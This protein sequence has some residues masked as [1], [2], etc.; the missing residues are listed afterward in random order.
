[1][2]SDGGMGAEEYSI[3]VNTEYDRPEEIV[4]VLVQDRFYC[5]R[6]E[7]INELKKLQSNLGA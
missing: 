3:D 4:A 6:R 2:E 1:L 5:P 7:F